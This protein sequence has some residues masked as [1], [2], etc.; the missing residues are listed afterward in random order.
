M[1]NVFDSCDFEVE[2]ISVDE[3]GSDTSLSEVYINVLRSRQFV[4]IQV[5]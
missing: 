5:Q 4:D 2:D 3:Y 1:K